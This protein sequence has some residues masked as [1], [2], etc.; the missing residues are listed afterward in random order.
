MTTFEFT[1]FDIL[2]L[3]S[4]PSKL[5][6][7]IIPYRSKLLRKRWKLENAEKN[8]EY[9]INYRE[10]HREELREA[11][12]EYYDNHK[13]ENYEYCKEWRDRN[14]EKVKESSLKSNWRR[15]GLNEDEIESSYIKYMETTHC[16]ICGVELTIDKINT[17]TTKCMDHSHKT[18]KFRNILCI[19]CNS[20]LPRGT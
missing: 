9:N 10:E 20:S 11:R 16:D 19:L 4:P 12:R 14:P 8:N 2:L 1:P 18:G 6:E 13:E 3:N 5:N 15:G 17:K 7:T